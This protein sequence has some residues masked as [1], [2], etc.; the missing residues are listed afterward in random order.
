MGGWL[1]R[2]R[3]LPVTVLVL[4]AA[5]LLTDISGE[6]IYPLLPAFLAD[7]LG[8]SAW[9][10]G[11]IEGAAEATAAAFKIASGIWTDRL[12]KRKPLVLLGY[13][14]S[15][16]VRPLV[17]LATIWPMVLAVRISDRIGKGLRSSPRDALIADVTDPALRGAAYGVHS[18]MDHAGAVAG[19]LIAWALLTWSGVSVRGIF[20]LAAIP[21]ALVVLL[22]W[23]GVR[24]PQAHRPR[25]PAGEPLFLPY[26]QWPVPLRRMLLAVTVFALGNSADAFLLLRVH[27]AGV[28]LAWTAA[29]WAAHHVV[30]MVATYVGGALSDRL[31]RRPMVL[32]GWAV[33]A[34]VYLGFA[35]VD[36]MAGTVALFLAYG[37]YFGLCEPA[38]KAWIADL[39]PKDR[40]GAAFGVWQAA[41]GLGALPA[42]LLFGA[43]W[44]LA[45]PAAAFATGAALAA[46]AAILLLRVETARSVASADLAD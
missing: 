30:K 3:T 21:G 11:L 7:S 33:Y 6:M 5:S 45:G 43:L 38:E 4:G 13:S 19:P 35:L 22:L 44:S 34:A 8:A 10:L 46:V 28:P 26:A 40:R 12:G 39:A 25:R 1:T 14:L 29:L 36:S 41:V 27:D 23:R 42:S 24:E 37:L 16:V 15:G 9:A 32:G 17:G 2:A 20:F 18:A 31:G